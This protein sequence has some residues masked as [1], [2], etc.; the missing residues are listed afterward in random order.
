[1]IINEL[2]PWQM[3]L[4][5]Q[6]TKL[7]K[8]LPHALLLYGRRGIGKYDFALHYAQSLL[9]DSTE[10]D[11]SACGLCSS[12]H[13]FLQNNHPDFRLL[14]P[15]QEIANEDEVPASSTK[16]KPKSQI[17]VSQI[18]ELADFFAL[19]SHHS[20]GHRVIL[21][22]P[23]ESLNAASANALLKVLEEPPAG[24]I[25]ILVCHQIQ[26][27]LPT[28][29][30]RCHKIDMKL[31]KEDVAINWLQKNGVKNASEQLAYAGGSPLIALNTADNEYQTQIGAIEAF[32]KGNKLDPFSVAAKSL[33]SGMESAVINLQKWI[34]DLISCRLTGEVHYNIRYAATLQVLSKSVNLK[35]LLDFQR[36]LVDARKSAGHPLNHEMQLEGLLLQYTR[37]FSASLIS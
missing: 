33:G 3:E 22:H 37:M 21:I 19:S 1:M 18:R 25:F 4:L 24:V 31:P 35:Q 32:A 28:I 36:N 27:L 26:R 29:R 8:Q 9:C 14:T 17:A 15:E 30:S 5:A 16:N 13:W 34:Y 11:G 6:M 10:A 2:Y 23:A 12:C 20:G 7:R